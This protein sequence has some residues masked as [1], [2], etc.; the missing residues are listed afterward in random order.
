MTRKD[1]SKVAAK[2]GQGYMHVLDGKRRSGTRQP[3]T[4]D[5]SISVAECK[6]L[7]K[8]FE[9]G[10]RSDRLEELCKLLQLPGDSLRSFGAGWDANSRLWTF[11]M[12]DGRRRVC[13]FR[14]RDRAGNKR[15]L[16]GSRNGVFLP[17]DFDLYGQG[18]LDPMDEQQLVLLLPEGPSDA[19]AAH[20]M[21]YRA[22]GRPSNMGGAEIIK[23]ILAEGPRYDLIIIAD[24]DKTKRL[25]DGTPF[26]PGWEGALHL[27]QIILP[28]TAS[29]KIVRM[30]GGRK[31]FRLWYVEGGWKPIFESLCHDAEVMT[32]KVIKEKYAKL[33][34]WKK[35]GKAEWDKRNKGG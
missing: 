20:A 14:T 15:S 9:S 31:D 4:V 17:S 27:A 12:Y 21:G 33:D 11:P 18:I 6:S 5:E 2:D 34:E 35:A 13:G 24:N 23:A 16:K 10:L 26:V 22:I 19:S 7:Q 25:K 8:Q 3:S 32:A 29:L 28:V 30:P 1:G